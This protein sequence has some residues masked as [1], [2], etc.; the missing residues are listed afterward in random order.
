MKNDLIIK[1]VGFNGAVLMA[2][3]EKESG[4]IH[5]GISWVCNGIGFTKGQKDRQ[6]ENIQQDIVL[7]RGCRKFAAGVFDPNNETLAIELKLLPLWL[8]KITITPTMQKEQPE[9]TERLVEYQLKAADVLAE[10]FLPQAATG[11]HKAEQRT[12]IKKKPV[13][14][15]FRQQF[16]LAETLIRHTGIKPGIAYAT[17]ISETEKQAG[18]SLDAYK[19]LLPPAEHEVG[20]LNATEVGSRLGLSARE[21]NTILQDLGLQYKDE[22]GRW[23]LTEAGRIYGE[24]FP[25]E[26]NGHS[27]YQARW[28]EAVLVPVDNALLR[29]SCE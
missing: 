19:K 22:K 5:V 23:R 20:L 18:A 9:L 2:A 4:K 10:A 12:K 16:N 15:I 17:A 8:A 29:R 25:F 28:G 1:E 3:Q 6:I 27:D 26:R 21:A 11:S 13:D 14:L 7:K 24:E